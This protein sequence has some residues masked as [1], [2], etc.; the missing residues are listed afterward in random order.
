MTIPHPVKTMIIRGPTKSRI[1]LGIPLTTRSA[2]LS[3]FASRRH[4][5]IYPA[6]LLRSTTNLVVFVLEKYKIFLEITAELH[7][8]QPFHDMLID[9]L[10]TEH[11]TEVTSVDIPP[12]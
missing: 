2:D 4:L 10:R 1:T 7:R 5:H 9:Y 11:L 6:S 12:A 8:H 3:P